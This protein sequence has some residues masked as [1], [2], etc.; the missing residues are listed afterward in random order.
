MP[1]GHNNELRA[2]WI[3]CFRSLNAGELEN[4]AGNPAYTNEF[5]RHRQILA[6]WMARSRDDVGLAIYEDKK[7]GSWSVKENLNENWV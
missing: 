5:E 4:I 3:P 7:E 1:T 6:E 2:I